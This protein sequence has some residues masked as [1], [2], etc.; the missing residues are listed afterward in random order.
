MQTLRDI[1]FEFRKYLRSSAPRYLALTAFKL[2][3]GLH[4]TSKVAGSAGVNQPYG[5]IVYV[6]GGG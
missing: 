5:F 1:K 3:S 6:Y 2:L 4:E